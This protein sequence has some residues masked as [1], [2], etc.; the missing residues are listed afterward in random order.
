MF[1]IFLF[2]FSTFL[3]NN[4]LAARESDFPISGF[5]PFLVAIFAFGES[6]HFL[7]FRGFFAFL[8]QCETLGAPVGL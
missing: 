3:G 6:D 1:G 7:V 4:R 2:W 8:S 5:L